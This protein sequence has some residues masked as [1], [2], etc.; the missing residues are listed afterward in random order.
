MG[1]AARDAR[2]DK[3]R[4]ARPGG[5][6]DALVRIGKWLIPAAFLAVFAWLAVIPFLAR[7]DNSFLLDKEEVDRAE[8][9]MRVEEAR[10]RGE[11]DEGRSFLIVAAEAVQES[12][13]VPIVVIRGM[14]ARLATDDGPV[15]VV[16]PRARYDIEEKLVEVDG[17]LEARGPDSY[18]LDTRDVVI[19]LDT[20][21]MRADGGVSGATNVGTF[22]ARSMR[23]DL[24]SRTVVLEGGVRLKIEQGAFR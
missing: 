20:N 15:T 4:W 3:R 24:D 11:D 18:R 1:R 23:A 6:H 17:P 12:S 9:R 13:R 10:Y 22:A 16:A 7:D 2:V 8:E 19:D 5:G 21:E 14:A